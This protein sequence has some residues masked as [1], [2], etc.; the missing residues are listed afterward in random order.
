MS[1]RH[2]EI[3]VQDC[4]LMEKPIPERTNQKK[5][6]NGEEKR[7]SQAKDVEV[8]AGEE[9]EVHTGIPWLVPKVVSAY[10]AFFVFG[11]NDGA[12]G[13][14]IPRIEEYYHISHAVA[15]L[16]FLM[17]FVGY[18][19]ACST[20]SLLLTHIFHNMLY[21][22]LF[23]IATQGLCYVLLCWG[24]PLPL[25]IIS[26]L[27][28]GLGLG[29]QEAVFNTFLG[30]LPGATKLLGALHGF[31]GL[32]AAVAPIIVTQG[33]ID[34]GKVWHDY[35]FVMIGVSVLACVFVGVAYWSERTQKGN[36][37]STGE[38]SVTA[39][40][41]V[42]LESEEEAKNNS[43]DLT[44]GQKNL[45]DA[46][47]YSLT[48]L[49]GI[50]CLLYV[51]MEF[52]LGGW[53]VSYMEDVRHASESDAGWVATG[54]FLGITAGRFVLPFPTA[55]MGEK[56]AGTVYLCVVLA[57]H[58]LFWLIPHFIVGAICVSFLGFFLGPLFPIA[59]S[60]ASKTLP[61][62]VHVSAI[63]F[64][65]AV[66]GAGGAAFPFIAGVVAS[67]RGVSAIQG[68]VIGLIGAMIALWIVIPARWGRW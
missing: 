23:A 19:C 9:G 54:F 68:L 58:L 49:F 65:A 42:P 45:K 48:W 50:F 15:S 38:E 51:G 13:A 64:I 2:D 44:T 31:Y 27:F 35:Y 7:Q 62:E 66:G 40:V 28:S 63:G 36:S 30:G 8:A 17:Q 43:T 46:L 5:A 26:Y 6:T 4:Y 10:F 52:A 12:V 21:I 32:G 47:K 60:L 59:V 67:A 53:V 61:R 14:L 29:V 57:L 1:T 41:E 22:S 11:L 3:T 37:A 16:V 56:L 18:I 33:L 34:K 20:A 55:R 25:F 24:P 39:V